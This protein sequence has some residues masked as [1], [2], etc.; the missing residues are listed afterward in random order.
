[1]GKGAAERPPRRVLFVCSG[2][3][4][5]SPTAHWVFEQML[6]R[7]GLHRGRDFEVRS[8]GTS[9]MSDVPVQQELVDWATEIYVME[10]EHA[11]PLRRRF[12]AGDVRLR[13]LGI[14]D[15]YFRDEPG[16]VV[17]LHAVLGRFV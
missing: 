8:A 3:Q 11:E 15:E 17:R 5:R 2:H 1:M 10:D 12:G 6:E 13:V 7:A 4:N 16:L 9:L 14:P